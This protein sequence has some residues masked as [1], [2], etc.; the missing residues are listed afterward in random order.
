[1]NTIREQMS[2]D[3]L[4]YRQPEITLTTDATRTLT[5]GESGAVI[6]LDK[7][8]GSVVT[9][10]KFTDV[11]KPGTFFDFMV[12]TSVTSNTYKIITGLGTE[13]LIGGYTSIDT[14]SSNAMARFTANGSTHISINMTAAASNALGGLIGTKLRLTQV[15]STQWEVE[16]VVNCAG[17]PATAFATS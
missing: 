5:V 4:N 14:D 6:I 8:D 15:S 16:G 2:S 9:L 3:K 17:T 11:G 12:K 1:M 10:P 13:L 7:A